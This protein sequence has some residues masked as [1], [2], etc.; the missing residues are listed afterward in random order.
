[1]L[2]RRAETRDIPALADLL[3]QVAEVH[4][5]IRPDLFKAGCRKYTDEELEDMVGVDQDPIFVAELDGQVVG[6]AFCQH[7]ER[8]GDNVLHDVTTLYLD[9]LCVDERA[10]GHAVG[11]ALYEYVVDYA[12]SRGYHNLT[13]NVWE[14]NDGAVAFY[15][16]LGLKPQ[17]TYLE[18]VL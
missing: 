11:R 9:D 13:L 6:Y 17:K 16:R 12:R 5:K 2:I 15:E 10:R 14:G 4:R 8:R 1:M 3:L 7:Q 18:Q